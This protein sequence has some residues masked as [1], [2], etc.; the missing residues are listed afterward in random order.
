[1]TKLT[2]ILANPPQSRYSKCSLSRW[3]ESLPEEDKKSVIAALHNPE[4]S[5][6]Q[7]TRSLREFGMPANRNSIN[8]H[9]NGQC[10]RCELI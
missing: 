1:M 10:T 9:R 5:S 6:S 3:V 7:L 2:D 8:E 4:W